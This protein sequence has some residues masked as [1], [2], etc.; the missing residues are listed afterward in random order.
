[1][2]DESGMAGFYLIGLTGNLGCG[3]STVRRFLEELGARGIDADALAHRVLARGTTA[4]HTVVETFG[5]DL[6]QP[7]GEIDRR[8][9]G[10]RVFGHP[11]ALKRLEEITHPAVDALIKELLRANDRPVVVLEAIKLVESGLAGAC[12]A[13]WVVTCNADQEVQRVVR[14]RG[15]RPEDARARLA[16]QSSTAEKL[17]LATV[18]IDNSGDLENTRLQVWTAW[19][20][21]VRPEQ[22]RD[23]TAWLAGV[24]SH[25]P[26]PL[27]ASVSPSAR[28]EVRRAR[29][30]DLDALAVALGQYEHREAPL[31]HDETLEHF[32]ERG[33]CIALIDRRIIALAAWEAENLVAIT[34]ET[35]AESADLA[36]RALPPLLEMVER[37]ARALLCE[38]SVLLLEPGMPS[39]VWQAVQVAGYQLRQLRELHR[40]WKQVVADRIRPGD[41]I[42]VKGLSDGVATRPS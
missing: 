13:L 23:K 35:W 12:D 32:R 31:S 10:A 7:D 37:D 19:K 41:E 38:V 34:R 16:A 21:T 8:K 40:L 20:N 27:P 4:Y 3:K 30:A 28:V 29:R 9:L 17:K 25:G 2:N 39:Y 1:M 22:A 6:L 18:V 42:W 24:G 26:A 14:D 11:E 5:A 33:Y 15:M 36:A